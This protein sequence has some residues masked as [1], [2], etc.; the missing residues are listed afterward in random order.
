MRYKLAVETMTNTKK[1][2]VISE[3]T[4]K[5]CTIIDLTPELEKRF[6]PVSLELFGYLF[7]IS[8]IDFSIY[9]R[10]SDIMIEFITAKE[11]SKELLRKLLIS[12]SKENADIDICVLKK[13]YPRFQAVL[14]RVRD[15]KIQNLLAKDPNL[16]RKTLDLFSD[17][18]GA[19]Q[20][21]IKGGIDKN[22]AFQAEQAASSLVANLMNSE[23]AIGTLSRMVLADPTLY[24]HS[25]AVA[26]IAGVISSKILGKDKDVARRIALGG[27][28]HD[29]GKTCVPNHI[30]NKPGSFTSE[31]FEVM[32]THTS[33]GYD[34]L[35]KAIEKGAPIDQEVALVALQHHEKFCG[36][37]YPNNLTGRLEERDDGIHEFARIVTIADVYSALLMKR[38]Y[39]EAFPPEQALEIMKKNAPKDYDPIVFQPFLTSVERSTDYYSMIEKT[40]DKGRIILIDDEKTGSY[41]KKSS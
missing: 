24:D 29:V 23:I 11:F 6:T 15:Q 4:R 30:L 21:V 28:Y 16:D 39:K 2:Y 36:G 18:S 37:G 41:Q 8:S 7:E 1:T 35:Q 14:N 5:R 40:R 25:A 33:L 13:D 27:L 12:N 31:E 10:C 26:M 9:F 20:M 19:S 17:L 34:E 38:V 22:V 3:E 32:K